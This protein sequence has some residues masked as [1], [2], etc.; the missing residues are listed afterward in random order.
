MARAPIEFTE[1]VGV[2]PGTTTFQLTGAEFGAHAGHFKEDRTRFY[3]PYGDFMKLRG[4]RGLRGL[5]SMTYDPSAG[6]YVPKGSLAATVPD[7]YKA[8]IRWDIIGGIGGGALLIALTAGFVA[9]VFE[10]KEEK[11]KRRARADS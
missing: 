7:K 2:A 10:V 11:R 3:D 9:A 5:G 6:S 4:L 1:A 8:N